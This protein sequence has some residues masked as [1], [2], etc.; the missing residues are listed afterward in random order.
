MPLYHCVHELTAGCLKEKNI[1]ETLV[2]LTFFLSVSDS[3]VCF[4][5]RSGKK[6][7][8]RQTEGAGVKDTAAREQ[9]QQQNGGGDQEGSEEIHTSRSEEKVHLLLRFHAGIC[10][11]TLAR[12]PPV[13]SCWGK[14]LVWSVGAGVQD[15]MLYFKISFYVLPTCSSSCRVCL[16]PMTVHKFYSCRRSSLRLQITIIM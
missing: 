10:S 2:Y 8:G 15:Y 1:Q 5:S 12:V 14:M 9:T 11:F 3:S 6:S 4:L 16:E 13:Y 7:S